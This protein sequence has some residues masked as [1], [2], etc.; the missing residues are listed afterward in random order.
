MEFKLS[1]KRKELINVL[2][3]TFGIHNSQAWQIVKLFVEQDK[4]F[5]RLLKE[6]IENADQVGIPPTIKI[7]DELAG[8]I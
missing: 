3:E 4:E 1:D 8:D 5:V 7:I 6:R 2:R